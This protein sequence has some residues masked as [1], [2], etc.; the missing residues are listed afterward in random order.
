[1]TFKGQVGNGG[2]A[3][4]LLS[5]GLCPNRAEHTIAS[6]PYCNEHFDRLI[7]AESKR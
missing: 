5:G 1:M 7:P 3:V 6:V 4:I 2:C